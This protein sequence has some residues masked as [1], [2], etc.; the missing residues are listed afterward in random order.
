MDYQNTLN[1]PR[2][3][4]PM[5]A[6]LPTREP[7][8][9]AT[10]TANDTYARTADRPGADL[11]VLHDGPPYSNG[12]IHMGHALN[13]ILKDFIV[14]YKSLTGRAAP[15]VPGWDNHGLPIEVNVVKE[16]RAKKVMPD[17]ITLRKRCREYAAEFVERQ[18]GQF[19]R[20]G[21]RGDWDHPYLTMSTEFEAEIVRT[22]G[23]M[24][25][26][27]FVYRGMKPV[28]WCPVDETALANHEVEYVEGKKDTSIFVRFPLKADPHGVFE[29]VDPAH[30]FTV[31]WTTTPWTIPSNV[32][33]AVSPVFDY[34]VAETGAGDRYVVAEALLARTMEAAGIEGYR[35]V[36]RL[37]GRDLSGLVFLHPLHKSGGPL[38]RESVLVH[39]DYVTVDD[40]TGVVH[41]APGH[42][43]EDFQT[44]Q[45]YNLPMI[46]P[47][48]PNGVY[49]A[50]AGEF[51]GLNLKDGGLRVI[52]RLREEGNLLA[53]QEI[54]HSYPHC[55][56]CH[57]PVIFRATVQWFMAIDHDEHRFK[58]LEA[59]KGV[60]W[61]PPESINRISAMVAGRPD[62][63]LSRQRAWGV[64]IPVFYCGDCSEPIMNAESIGAV[65][66]LTRAEGSDAWFEKAPADILPAG[67]RCPRCGGAPEGFTK[68][69]DVLDVW[70]DSGS[71][72]RAVLE[73]RPQLRFPA[74]VYLE[75][76][77]Q[78]RGWFN[79]SLMVGVSTRDQAPFRQVISHGFL[80]DEKGR[81][82]SK[83]SGNGIAPATV[84][85]QYGADVLRLWVASI[86][87]F[88]DVRFGNNIL[89]QTGEAYRKIRNTLRYLLGA[90]S[91]F[92]PGVDS[93]DPDKLEEIDRWVLDRLQ[94]VVGDVTNGYETYEFQRA[95]RAILDFCA[96]D[97]SSFYFDVLKDRLYASAPNDGVRRSSQ[98]ALHEI[99]SV[100]CR[101]I[102][103][104]LPH[105][106]EEAWQLLPGAI[107][108]VSPSVEL[109]VFPTPDALYLDDDLQARWQVLLSVRDDVNRAL[110][111]AKNAGTVKKT[112]E[113]AVTLGGATDPTAGFT[114]DELATLFLVSRVSRHPSEASL[115]AVAPAEGV[116]CAR[117][118]L[119]KRD[120]G[121]DSEY[122]DICGR[123]AVAVRAIAGAETSRAD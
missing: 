71:T 5:K 15:Y 30:C 82:M 52:E 80:L 10:W 28:Y 117:C 73:L 58:A 21:I 14:R 90:L 108:T 121:K 34:V 112:L 25:E 39:A 47:V 55:W 74:D 66:D 68:E 113:A 49:D 57:N 120:I 99:A 56:R 32:A 94:R 101:L 85:E 81:A 77:D 119:I 109:S 7:G 63:C 40:G 88:E 26:K 83:S 35:V 107:E 105:T 89:K 16:F 2:T 36:R 65:Y 76:S 29:G 27:G 95:T 114:D 38:D 118:W 24:V 104:I 20:L 50:S 92:T 54:V 11:F 122:A 64:G 106:A 93:V 79:S 91:D 8:I 96:I 111:N 44:G 51:E 9:A 60:E 115:I 33:V 19:Q 53:E 103:P 3:D 62:W 67:F 48:L 123:C 31:I 72:C 41:T 6:D 75:G 98:T 84:V 116:K 110:E 69:T 102:A 37:V 70:F 87:Y 17:K 42:G 61:F 22:F 86:D 59:I 78:H 18:K 45:A 43:A 1:L 4:F 23:D 12:D 97:L 100:L 13:K 46:Q